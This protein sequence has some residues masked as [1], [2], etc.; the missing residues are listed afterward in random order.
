[1]RP[2]GIQASIIHNEIFFIKKYYNVETQ[3]HETE[4][5]ILHIISQKAGINS[6]I[7]VRSND[8][9]EQLSK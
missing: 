9:T 4:V 1:M 8:S 7:V 2:L 6:V 5:L 3:V